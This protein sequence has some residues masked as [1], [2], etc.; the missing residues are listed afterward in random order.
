M[1]KQHEKNTSKPVA[2]AIGAAFV[3]SL[4]ASGSALAASTTDTN[5]FAMQALN[6]GYM[7]AEKAEGKCGEGKCGA[8]KDA[9]MKK[10]GSCGNKQEVKEVKEGKCGE[11]KCGA[12]K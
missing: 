7:V 4:A 3:T 8:S 6:N 5:P 2:L 9:K 1:S 11:G 12:K 10:E